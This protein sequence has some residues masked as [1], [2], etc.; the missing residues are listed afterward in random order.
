MYSRRETALS[1]RNS[2]GKHAQRRFASVL[3]MPAQ[4]RKDNLAGWLLRPM[5]PYNM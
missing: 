2:G 4:S 1:F 3:R 5:L